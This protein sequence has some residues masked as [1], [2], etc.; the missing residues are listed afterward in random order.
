MD[1]W[2]ER[3]EDMSPDGRLQ[4]FLEPDGDVVIGIVKDGIMT[5]VEFC[6]PGSGGGRSRNTIM[7][8]RQLAIAMEKDNKNDNTNNRT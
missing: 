8:L 5:S 3:F 7:A 1:P 6:S 4:I 2:T